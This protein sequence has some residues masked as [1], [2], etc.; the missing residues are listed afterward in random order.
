MNCVMLCGEQ[1]KQY[2]GVDSVP[3]KITDA[4][5]RKIPNSKK[6]TVYAGGEVRTM[7]AGWLKKQRGMKKT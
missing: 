6:I 5:L 3:G 2:L 7:T 1:P 4:E